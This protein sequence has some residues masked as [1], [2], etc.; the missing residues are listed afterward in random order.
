MDIIKEFEV[1]A[2]PSGKD[3]KKV[4]IYFDSGAQYTF[5]KEET[6]LKLGPTM[7]L[8]ELVE[9]S[10]LGGGNFISDSIMFLNILLEEYWCKW[11]VYVVNSAL[12]GPDYDILAGHDFMQEY[13]IE[14]IPEKGIIKID[15]TRLR[16]AQ[17]VR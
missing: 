12:F 13:G 4:N 3:S 5:I 16:L 14:L 11:L 15:K 9:F 7:K 17:Q 2:Y 1:S 8:P 10:G 6:A